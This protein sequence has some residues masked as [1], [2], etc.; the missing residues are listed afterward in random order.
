MR[1]EFS[2]GSEPLGSIRMAGFVTS[3]VNMNLSRKILHHEVC[4]MAPKYGK[5]WFEL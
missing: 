2:G 4:Q 1:V 5:M 3:T